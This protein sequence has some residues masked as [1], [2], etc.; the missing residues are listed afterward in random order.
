MM[1]YSFILLLFFFYTGRTFSQCSTHPVALTHQSDVAF[2]LPDE[3][4]SALHDQ[5][6][7]AYL[8]VAGKERGLLVYDVSII[9]APVLVDSVKVTELDTLELMSLT[10]DGNYLYLALGNIFVNSS[11]PGMA[12]VDVTNP[13]SVVVKSVWKYPTQSGGAGGV[14]VEGNYTYLGAMRRGLMIFDVTDKTNPALLSVFKPSILY[15]N[16]TSPDSLKYNARGLAVRSSIVYLCDDAGGVRIINATNKALPVETG[17]YSNP[18][19]YSKAR[20]YNNVILDDTLLYVAADYC[21]M[22]ILSINDTAH[23]NQVGWWNPWHCESPANTWFNSGGHT[24]EI[25]Y[26]PY[27]KDVFLASGKSEVN[28]VNVSNPA[29]PDS[30]TKYTTAGGN[31]GV[32]G[33]TLFGEQLYACYIYVP[34]GIPFFGNWSG[35]KAITWNPCV[36]SMVQN[37]EPPGIKVYP[38]PSGGKF[39]VRL[40]SAIPGDAEIYVHDVIGTLKLTQHLHTQNDDEVL[41]QLSDM[42]AGVYFVSVQCGLQIFN[43]KIL[44]SN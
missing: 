29:S 40:P 32:W 8:Y 20:A 3:C 24:N 7:R 27:C 10:Q 5:A 13:T 28:V 26:D 22:E 34:L 30:C 37:S 38:N 35:F 16:P 17:H 11:K 33:I 19:V 21:G 18:A 41:V 23:I 2:P 44:I 6:G 25:Q 12:I 9:T 14:K 4:M 36:S 1:K 15:P 42:P 43:T 39:V 31:V